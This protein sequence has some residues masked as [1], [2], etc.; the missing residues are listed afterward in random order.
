MITPSIRA[1]RRKDCTIGERVELA[2]CRTAATAEGRLY[3]QR[4]GRVVRVTDVPTDGSGRA[5]LVERGLEQDGDAAVLALVRDYVD[6]ANR[7]GIPP[8][9]AR[10]HR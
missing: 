10:P 7:L 2:W 4:V 8:M 6:Q 9:A 5:Y 3:A 1:T